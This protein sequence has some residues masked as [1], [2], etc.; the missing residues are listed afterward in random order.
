MKNLTT[1][2]FFILTAFNLFAGK[3]DMKI[4]YELNFDQPN[5]HLMIVTMTASGVDAKTVDFAIPAWRPGRYAIQNYSRLIQEFS[6]VDQN[7]NKLNFKKVDKDT[8]RVTTNGATTV[9]V[10]YK[11]FAYI[12]DAGSTWYNEEEIYFNGVNLFMYIPEYKHLPVNLTIN[13]PENW[14]IATGLTKTG[15]KTFSA[16]NYDDFADCPTI[17]SPT[18]KHEMV[19]VNGTNIH[20]WVQGE[21]NADLKTFAADI[22]KMAKVQF[23]F[24]G[25]VPFKEYHFLFHFFDKPF[26][27][28]VEHKNSTSIC[29]G[30]LKDMPNPQDFSRIHGVTSHELFHAWNI[31]TLFPDK[32]GPTF[33]YTKENYTDLLYFSEGFTSYYGDYLLIKAG[34]LTEEKYF[35]SQAKDMRSY[36]LTPG[37]SIQTLAESSQDAW[38]T[39]YGYDGSRNKLVNFYG[40]GELLGLLLDLEIRAA[41]SNKKTFGDVMRS[42]Y[43]DFAK[44][45]KGF[46]TEDFVKALNS[47]SGKDMSGLINDYVY[48]IKPFDFKSAFAKNGFTLTTEPD[49][50]SIEF[51]T[52]MSLRKSDNKWMVSNVIPGSAAYKAGVDMGDFILGFNDKGLPDS[53]QEK[54]FT[55]LKNPETI[56]VSGI[57]RGKSITFNLTGLNYS[58]VKYSISRNADN[59]KTW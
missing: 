27:H 44:K 53:D 9:S 4:S 34:L 39:G 14:T 56:K 19:T 48:T 40:K 35:A 25:Y 23:E 24:W 3:D 47:V 10:S 29:V 37:N 46:T 8:W 31:K 52:G 11:F 36:E 50:N 7:K 33:D 42:L 18:V 59:T 12:L 32:I 30:P 43:N 15:N 49:N 17:I 26:S 22:E 55:D 45:N 51:A 20:V 6:A 2:V 28:G 54:W 1:A 41:T 21:T 5:S 57:R 13:S 38:L 16:P 58:N